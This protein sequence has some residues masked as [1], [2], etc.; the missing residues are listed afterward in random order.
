MGVRRALTIEAGFL[1][2]AAGLCSYLANEL[3]PI[4]LALT[5][6]SHEFLAFWQS[7]CIEETWDWEKD[8]I[9]KKNLYRVYL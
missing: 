6:I 3:V 7:D 2:A 4:L 5:P 1:I 9:A 8:L